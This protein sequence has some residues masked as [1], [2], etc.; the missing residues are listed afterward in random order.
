MFV[1][2]RLLLLF[3]KK[4]VTF[5]FV[6][7]SYILILKKKLSPLYKNRS[8][9][10][11]SCIESKYSEHI[12]YDIGIGINKPTDNRSSS[13]YQNFKWPGKSI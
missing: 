9:D 4:K 2:I 3:I 1:A 13:R 5:K 6:M 7:T 8:S 10:N 11:T 12:T